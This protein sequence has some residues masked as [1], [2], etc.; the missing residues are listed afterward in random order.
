MSAHALTGMIYQPQARDMKVSESIWPS[1]FRDLRTRG[2]D[3]LVV[4]WTQVG[5]LFENDAEKQWL[6][7]RLQEA[8]AADLKLVLGL[9]A[10][11]DSFSSLAIPTDLLEDYFLEMNEK[12]LALAKGWIEVLPKQSIVG[13]YLPTEIDDRRWRA[14]GDQAVLAKQ[15]ARDVVGLKALNNQPVYISSFFK[16]NTAPDEY[17]AMLEFLKR[18]TDLRIWVQDGVGTKSLLPAETR[19]YLKRLSVCDDMPVAGIVYE[20]FQQV[21]PDHQFKA[22][23]LLAEPLKRALQQRAPCG[24]DSVFFSLRYLFSFGQ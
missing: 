11:P 2:F 5:E 18:S 22:E 21:G 19:L 15:L 6:S 14:Q 24:G 8:V 20:I 4:Q 12:S 16:G 7:R 13:W 10:D 3:T 23:P 17:K 1:M 9:Y